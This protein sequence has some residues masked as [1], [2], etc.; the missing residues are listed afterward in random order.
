MCRQVCW[1]QLFDPMYRG[2]R[3][4]LVDMARW[5]FVHAPEEVVET[6]HLQDVFPRTTTEPYFAEALEQPEVMDELFGLWRHLYVHEDRQHGPAVPT[7]DETQQWASWQVAQRAAGAGP[8]QHRVLVSMVDWL[9][10]T[11][12]PRI[13]ASSAREETFPCAF[14]TGGGATNAAPIRPAP[15]T[16]DQPPSSSGPTP[17]ASGAR[18]RGSKSKSKSKR[19][20]PKPIQHPQTG[21][22]RAVRRRRSAG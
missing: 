15:P 1:T 19:R 9:E 20:K 6:L 7:S 14:A 22:H 2:R 21:R 10:H 11:W 3:P 5:K 8:E 16:S 17:P 4:R 12:W 18:L 13:L